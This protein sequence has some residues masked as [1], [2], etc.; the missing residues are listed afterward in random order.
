MRP[1]AGATLLEIMVAMVILAL[2][3]S[4]VFG[5]LVFSRR[6]MTSSS[7]RLL[8]LSY[9]EQVAEE[10]RTEIGS[11]SLN[12]A[13]PARDLPGGNLMSSLSSPTRTY[14]IRNGKFDAAGAIV[15]EPGLDARG[16][17]INDTNYDF[18]EVR[19]NVTWQQ[20]NSG[21]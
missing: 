3:A 17:P 21:G 2:L 4:G 14:T 20:P 16:Q 12:V 18:K 7:A 19:V 13:H 11:N 6:T 10:L 15:W 5:A 9:A 1:Q 8:A